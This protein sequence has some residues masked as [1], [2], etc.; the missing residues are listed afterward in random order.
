MSDS[1]PVWKRVVV[2]DN[3]PG[4]VRASGYAPSM[5]QQAKEDWKILK[6]GLTPQQQKEREEEVALLVATHT[7]QTPGP[8]APL[9]K[10]A[11]DSPGNT[12]E[13]R[14]DGSQG[15]GGFP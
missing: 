12:P 5:L 8:R 11:I 2:I 10:M 15:K 6:S 7:A 14:L 4:L 3:K 1:S 13:G 9:V